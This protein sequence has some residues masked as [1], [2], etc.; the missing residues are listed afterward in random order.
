VDEA[1]RVVALPRRIELVEIGDVDDLAGEDA[2]ADDR[3]RRHRHG[4]AARLDLAGVVLRGDEAQG[5]IA[6]VVGVA[7]DDVDRA[8]V[9]AGDLAGLGQDALEQLGDV[10]LLRQ[11]APDPDEQIAL[12]AGPLDGQLAAG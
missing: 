12:V 5:P 11:R 1:P 2:G 8:G 7:L 4:E 3:G 6:G 10:A 9:G